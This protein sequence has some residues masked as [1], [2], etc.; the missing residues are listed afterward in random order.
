MML[1]RI[2]G[3]VVCLWGITASAG[4]K[5]PLMALPG[6]DFEQW[7]K[8][9]TVIAQTKMLANISPADGAKGAVLASPERLD[10]DYYYHWIRDSALV[11]EAILALYERSSDVQ[12]KKSLLQY[13][14][15]FAEFS[16][17]IQNVSTL[18][19]LGEPRFYV[20][21]DAYNGPW[22]RPQNDGPAMR[23]MTLMHL[24]R[25]LNAT[26][27]SQYFIGMVWPV[28]RKDLQ[29]VSDQWPQPCYDLWEEI[30]GDHFYTQMAQRAALLQGADLAGG[31]DQGFAV[32][33]KT[34]ADLVTTRLDD[35]LV[36]SRKEIIENL[37]LVDGQRTKDDGLDTATLL[38]FL[39]TKHTP[40]KSFDDDFVLNTV[41]GID[42]QFSYIYPINWNHPGMGTA[43]GRYSGDSYYGG[44]PWF[45]TTLAFA[46]FNYELAAEK[47]QSGDPAAQAE[48]EQLMAHGD[49][50]LSRVRLHMDAQ[51]AMSEQMNRNTGYMLSAHD[52]TWS[53]AAWL[54]A[55]LSRE[56]LSRKLPAR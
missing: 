27:F 15:D 9:E 54:T 50:Y 2:L 12:E 32:W 30:K 55:A 22:S 49:S 39:H 20:T 37:N 24:G 44:N 42:Q 45:L 1:K 28:I 38:A 31:I 51:G 43:I 14:L 46:E 53:Y 7:I 4:M 25:V 47:L 8:D 21:G 26:G 18:T 29:Y 17:K 40:W 3:G 33:L 36:V 41:H 34:Q 56:N 10:P 6:T 13:V 52:L 48:A 19:G 35:H 5:G 11:N 23:A 16:A